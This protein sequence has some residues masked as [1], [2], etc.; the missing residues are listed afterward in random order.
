MR[1]ALSDPALLGKVLGGESWRAW[2]VI[3]IAAA[4]EALD[5]D[6]R[7]IFKKLTGRTGEPGQRCD[8][9]VVVAG[10]RAG[11]SRAIACLV[12]YLAVFHAHGA[13]LAPG[14]KPTVLCL[15]QNR[16]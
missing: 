4:G 11:K 5:D 8:E 3:L 2:R 1:R 13:K 6:E 10:R 14:E 9:L 12:V 15:A 16:P 7:V